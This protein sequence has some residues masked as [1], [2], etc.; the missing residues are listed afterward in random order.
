[1]MYL[2]QQQIRQ[3]ISTKHA[4]FLSNAAS[5]G[6]HQAFAKAIPGK[7]PTISRKI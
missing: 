4:V 1:M 6:C 5:M 3:T 2:V 7:A